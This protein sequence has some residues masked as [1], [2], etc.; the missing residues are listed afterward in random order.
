MKVDKDKLEKT[1]VDGVREIKS[2]FYC[3]TDY[4]IGELE[5]LQVVLTITVDDDDFME[6]DG[7]NDH[8]CVTN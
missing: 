7:L 2:S 8:V 6:T 3:R 5:G 4:L 1:I